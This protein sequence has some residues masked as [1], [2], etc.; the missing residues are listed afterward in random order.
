VFQQD[1]D[2]TRS[3]LID[4]LLNGVLV[5][6]TSLT[7]GDLY[8]SPPFDAGAVGAQVGANVLTVRQAGGDAEWTNFDFHRL[9]AKV[10]PPPPGD[11]NGDGLVDGDDYELFRQAYGRCDGDP[12]YRAEADYD[13]D[14]CVTLLDYQIWLQHYGEANDLPAHSPPNWSDGG[15]WQGVTDFVSCL[16][17]PAQPSAM[18]CP[19]ADLNAD[20]TVDLA[21]FAVLQLGIGW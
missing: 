5:H 1:G 10:L 15:D 9:E 8:I 4:V 16:T 18:D 3:V 21:D 14:G 7:A 17:G 2:G 13:Q 11:L 20:D 6:V 12:A 19:G